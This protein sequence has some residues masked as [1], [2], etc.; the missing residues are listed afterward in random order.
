MPC[1]HADLRTKCHEELITYLEEWSIMTRQQSTAITPKDT[2]AIMAGQLHQ[3]DIGHVL[4]RKAKGPPNTDLVAWGGTSHV[5][6]QS[7]YLFAIASGDE[8]QKFITRLEVM[9]KQVAPWIHGPAMAGL[10]QKSCRENIDRVPTDEMRITVANGLHEA[11]VEYGRRF[12]YFIQG[13]AAHPMMPSFYEAMQHPPVSATLKDL[14]MLTTAMR[15]NYMV[16]SAPKAAPREKTPKTKKGTP[17]PRAAASSAGSQEAAPKADAK[18]KL[19]PKPTGFNRAWSNMDTLS[20]DQYHLVGKVLTSMELCKFHFIKANCK[21]V[22][23]TKTEAKFGKGCCREKMSHVKPE[24]HSELPD[25]L[26]KKKDIVAAIMF[27]HVPKEEWSAAAKEIILKSFDLK[28]EQ[29]RTILTPKNNYTQVKTIQHPDISCARAGI[30]TELGVHIG[31][32]DTFSSKRY[33]AA[34]HEEVMKTPFPRPNEPKKKSAKTAIQPYVFN[35][36]MCTVK[37]MKTIKFSKAKIVGF[38]QKLSDLIPL[39]LLT[40]IH[41]WLQRTKA[42]LNHLGTPGRRENLHSGRDH[43]ILETDLSK[44]Y[45][46]TNQHGIYWDL[47]ELI[48]DPNNIG[49]STTARG[50]ILPMDVESVPKTGLKREQISQDLAS[51][52]NAEIARQMSGLGAEEP[53]TSPVTVLLSPPHKGAIKELQH[54]DELQTQAL[55]KGNEFLGDK[56]FEWFPYY[57]LNILPVNVVLR[58][59]KARETFDESWKTLTPQGENYVTPNDAFRLMEKDDLTLPTVS[60]AGIACKILK[61]L[62]TYKPKRAA[63]SAPSARESRITAF[64]LDFSKYY[65]RFPQHPAYLHRHVRLIRVGPANMKRTVLRVE[66]RTMFGSGY[67]PMWAQSASNAYLDTVLNR[68][69]EQSPPVRTPWIRAWQQARTALL[70]TQEQS[71]RSESELVWA[72]IYLDD[73]FGASLDEF[74]IAPGWIPVHELMRIALEVAEDWGLPT[75]VEKAILPCVDPLFLGVTVQIEKERYELTDER[76]ARW[77]ELAINMS[78]SP[79]IPKSELKS[80][81]HKFCWFC[82]QIE[83]DAM[84]IITPLFFVTRHNYKTDRAGCVANTPAI[85]E[86]LA[87][88]AA[89]IRKSK[90]AVHIPSLKFDDANAIH[91]YTDASGEGSKGFGGVVM[92]KDGTAAYFLTKFRPHEREMTVPIKE[93]LAIQIFTEMLAINCGA[94]T[95]VHHHTDSLTCALNAHANKSSSDLMSKLLHKVRKTEARFG[96]RRKL[97]HL[98]RRFNQPSDDLSKLDEAQFKQTMRAEGFTGTF[99]KWRVPAHVRDTRWLLHTPDLRTS[100]YEQQEAAMSAATKASLPAAKKRNTKQ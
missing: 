9:L 65:K 63:D 76:R 62:L 5:N 92:L 68:Y 33:T 88:I 51:H 82:Q 11:M 87:W 50:F 98:Y 6:K 25:G 56:E 26:G 83:P 48:I 71:N 27:K 58:N 3:L 94:G 73:D 85:R 30:P 52:A 17:A 96:M 19:H 67:M 64:V 43:E 37:A 29:P 12:S 22:L 46:T 66:E 97:S 99:T 75:S 55:K 78:K 57:P 61:S 28:C 44:I 32:K 15:A 41:A 69:N 60:D 59:D 93:G 21:A 2:L 90:G 16:R 34:D 72:T 20:T 10:L 36:F 14:K 23:D 77:E 47:R 4:D 8:W 79:R 40:R 13:K 100:E 45:M 49:D 39:E 86:K 74:E 54:W 18:K 24:E 89:A 7:Y 91:A 84:K 53:V 35:G 42:K 95:C 70:G 81:L 80:A 38:P 31:S 1:G